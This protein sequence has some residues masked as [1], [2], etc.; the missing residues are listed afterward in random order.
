MRGLVWVFLLMG[1]PGLVWAGSPAPAA[2]RFLVATTQLDGPVFRQTVVLL[3]AADETGAMG[4][5]VNRPAPADRSGRGG[6]AEAARG[7]FIGGPVMAGSL[8]VL[9]RDD[10]TAGEIGVDAGHVVDDVFVTTSADRLEALVKDGLDPARV[11]VYAGYAGWGPGQ[12]EGE[13]ARG[14]WKVQAATGAE[15]FTD[16]VEALWERLAGPMAPLTARLYRPPAS[17]R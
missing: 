10:R 1:G 3:V 7:L 4:L 13:I 14:D 12:L 16:R 8:F 15:I 6:S 9:F 17:G 5:V 2:G 11:R